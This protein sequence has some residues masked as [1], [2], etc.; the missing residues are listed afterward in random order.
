MPY[1]S[2]FYLS[3]G[4]QTVKFKDLSGQ[5]FGLWTVI[6]RG[7]N[8]GRHVSWLCRCKCGTER[9][10]SSTNLV[11]GT[12]IS[13]G[14]YRVNGVIGG[15]QS[16]EYVAYLAMKQRCF[17]ANGKGYHLYG[18]RGITVCQ[19]WLE[20]FD[21]FLS[22]MGRKPSPSHSLD[23]INPNKNYS[24]ENCRWATKE[25]QANNRRNNLL[26]TFDN[27]T[28]SAALWAKE[29]GLNKSC[30]IYRLKMGWPVEK[31]I[32]TPSARATP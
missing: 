13:C 29:K 24:P 2:I 31:A 4:K 10:V 12:S 7:N 16:A 30:L 15:H 26:L 22:D 18:G 23:R 25:E 28:Q 6:K 1:E 11:M 3:K 19:R 8:I 5:T 32:T 20:S 21:N 27:K 14:C 17:N 9:D